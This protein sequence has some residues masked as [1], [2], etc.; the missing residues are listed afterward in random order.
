MREGEELFM[1]FFVHLGPTEFENSYPLLYEL[2]D[3]CDFI[4]LVTNF[5]EL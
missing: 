1:T 2:D 4:L 5:K 3:Q